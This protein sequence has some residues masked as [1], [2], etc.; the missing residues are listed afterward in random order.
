MTSS[1]TIDFEP[2]GKRVL[3]QTGETLADSALRAGID[4]ITSCNGLGV[5]TSC[6]V[7]VM[8]GEVSPPTTNE[9]ARLSMLKHNANLRLACQTI[10]QSDVRIF[11]PAGSLT[12]GQQL[13]VDGHYHPTDLNTPFL[14]KTITILPPSLQDLRGDWERLQDTYLALVN[15]PLQASLPL[16]KEIPDRVRSLNWNVKLVVRDDGIQHELIT[17]LHP[18]DTYYG[19]AFDIGSTKIA[20]FLINLESGEMLDQ[21]GFMNPQIA[22]GEDIINR[23]SHAMQTPD[24]ARKLQDML[25]DRIN[26]Y[27]LETIRK[28]KLEPDQI[29]DMVVVGNTAIHHLFCGLPVKSLGEAPYVP[30]IQQSLSFSA[31]QHRIQIAPGAQI[32]LPPN[33]AGYVGADHT[34]AVLATRIQ[35]SEKTLCLIDIGTNTEISLIH[36]EKIHACSCA[37]GPA[38]EGAHIQDGMR[39]SPGAIDQVK[40]ENGL[41]K[42]STIGQKPPSGICGSGILSVMAEMRRN[43]IIDH[44]GV[45][46]HEHPLVD[47][48]QKLLILNKNENG[49]IIKITRKDVNE[50]QLAKGAIRSGIEILCQKTGIQPDQIDHFLIAGA[51]G[52]YLD[53]GSAIEIG[54][55]PDVP[56][57]NYTQIGNAAGAGARMLLVNHSQRNL[58]EQIGREIHY[59]ELTAETTFNDTYVSALFMEKNGNLKQ[60]L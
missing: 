48:E 59:I 58:A 39:A 13:Q 60:I 21:T 16:L 22:L 50:V 41:V 9:Q 15:I 27:L 38:F 26:Q 31:L 56:L 49:Q 8:E 11:I 45:F 25:V 10:P 6:K 54:M 5:C 12:Q 23:L 47:P 24:K 7:E 20:A 36:Q 40:I 37:S 17:L 28:F 43:H 51:F 44:R 55:F 30:A 42:L 35:E 1:F 32:Y 57:E 2:V 4:L 53:L 19:I 29:I 33:I 18:E 46:N 52:N 34:A 3:S 14:T